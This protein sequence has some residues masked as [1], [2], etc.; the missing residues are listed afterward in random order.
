[1]LSHD[2]SEQRVER[3]RV[4]LEGSTW[5]APFGL[6]HVRYYM[7]RFGAWALAMRSQPLVAISERRN[8]GSVAAGSDKSNTSSS[9]T[10]HAVA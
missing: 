10:G 1:M 7:A 3:V 8:A 2:N 4:R 5:S 6:D 9:I